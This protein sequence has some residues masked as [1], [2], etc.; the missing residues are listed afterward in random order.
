MNLLMLAL[1]ISVYV[2]MFISNQHSVNMHKCTDK[3]RQTASEAFMYNT[4]DNPKKA[5]QA[6]PAYP[7]ASDS[8]SQANKA[9]SYIHKSD[10]VM[11]ISAP[12]LWRI[13]GFSNRKAALIIACDTDA[14][15]DNAG[16]PVGFPNANLLAQEANWQTLSKE[17]KQ[18]LKEYFSK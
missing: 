12:R 7:L 15:L 11:V 16:N 3:A 4:N 14:R 5:A 17:Y 8:E 13:I 1:L 18:K 9:G 2:L 6:A 10:E